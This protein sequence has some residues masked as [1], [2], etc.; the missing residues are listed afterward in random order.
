VAERVASTKVRQLAVGKDIMSMCSE[1]RD[2]SELRSSQRE[3][4]T[5]PARDAAR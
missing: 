5:M 2:S 4:E 1:T 3:V